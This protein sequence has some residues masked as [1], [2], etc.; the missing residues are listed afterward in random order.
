MHQRRESPLAQM[1]SA[2][3]QRG[4]VVGKVDRCA[5]GKDHG[6]GLLV[7][8]THLEATITPYVDALGTFNEEATHP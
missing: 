5:T 7:G 3:E 2:V 1:V 6:Q 4:H 8:T